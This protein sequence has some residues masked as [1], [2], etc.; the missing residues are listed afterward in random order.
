MKTRH[1][2]LS[3]ALGK[4]AT[5]ANRKGVPLMSRGGDAK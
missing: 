3:T 2:I 5:I 1:Q 4:L